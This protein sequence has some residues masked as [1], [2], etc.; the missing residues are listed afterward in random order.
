MTD[1]KA[2]LIAHIEGPTTRFAESL[3]LSDYQ[4]QTLLLIR[5]CPDICVAE[6]CDVLDCRQN[7]MRS[8]LRVLREKGAVTLRYHKACLRFTVSEFGHKLLEAYPFGL[9]DAEWTPTPPP[10]GG[11]GRCVAWLKANASPI[12]A[13]RVARIC[14]TNADEARSAMRQLGWTHPPKRHRQAPWT[15]Q[16]PHIS[17]ESAQ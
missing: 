3:G 11:L 13:Q 14:E 1:A 17:P 15:W 10:L 16:P 2:C 6:L 5:K 7:N 4:C 12:T 8:R 9:V